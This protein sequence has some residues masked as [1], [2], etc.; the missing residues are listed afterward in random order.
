[1]IK[2]EKVN[3]LLNYYKLKGWWML[4]CQNYIIWYCRVSER[5]IPQP[6]AI[7]IFFYAPSNS[8]GIASELTFFS[9]VLGMETSSDKVGYLMTSSNLCVFY[10]PLIPE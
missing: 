9:S 8:L 4:I 1:M 7:W 2:C 3:K 6:L 10:E 5:L